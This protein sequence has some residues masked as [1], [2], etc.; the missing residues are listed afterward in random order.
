MEV[1]DM[2]KPVAESEND[3]VIAE[4]INELL[5]ARAAASSI[6]PS[7]VAR[8]LESDEAAWRELMPE[9]RR[10]AAKLA[11]QGKLRVT[12]GDDI[13]DAQS[14]GGPIRLRQPR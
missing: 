5:S 12:R 6:C 8:A 11:S 7:E 9:V 4:M 2:R 14:E 13:V 3:R 1:L 10:V